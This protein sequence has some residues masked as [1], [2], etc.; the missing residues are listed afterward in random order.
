MSSPSCTLPRTEASSQHELK[1]VPHEFRHIADGMK[2][3][4][5]RN[6]DRCFLV[7]D[8]I[9]FREWHPEDGYTG[10]QVVCRVTHITPGGQ[11]GLPEHL[12][13]LSIKV[14]RWTLSDSKEAND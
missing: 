8:I 2:T 3:H 7:W 10:S 4:D 11:W 12:C 14:E 9:T 13:V 1:S 5:V 6:N